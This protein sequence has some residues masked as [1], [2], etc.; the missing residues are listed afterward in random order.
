MKTKSTTQ[1]KNLSRD[2]FELY[3]KDLFLN[4]E[5]QRLFSD[6]KNRKEII[7]INS[8]LSSSFQHQLTLVVEEEIRRKVETLCFLQYAMMNSSGNWTDVGQERIIYSLTRMFQKIP[9][10]QPLS[11]EMISKTRTLLNEESRKYKDLNEDELNKKEEQIHIDLGWKKVGFS[12]YKIINNFL[13]LLNSNK[14]LILGQLELYSSIIFGSTSVSEFSNITVFTFHKELIHTPAIITSIAAMVKDQ[15]I[16]IREDSA[17]TIFYNKWVETFNQLRSPQLAKILKDPAENVSLSIKLQTLAAYNVFT[18][19]QLLKKKSLFIEEILE[20]LLWHEMGHAITLN[21]FMKKREIALDEAL[22]VM[23]E[24]SSSVAKEL[25]ADLAKTVDKTQGALQFIVSCPPQKATRMIL[26]YL[27]DNWFISASDSFFKNHTEIMISNILNFIDINGQLQQKELS[28]QIPIIYQ[29]LLDEYKEI[30]VKFL[31]MLDQEKYILNT[32]L[33]SFDDIFAHY[34]TKFSKFTRHF[35]KRE[36]EAYIFARIINDLQALNNRLFL[37]IQGDLKGLNDKYH[38]RI[39]KG[40]EKTLDTLYRNLKEKKLYAK[41]KI[42]LDIFKDR[43]S[44]NAT[45][46]IQNILDGK[47]N[48][49]LSDFNNDKEI[50]EFLSWLL[51]KIAFTNKTKMTTNQL[52]S[53]WKEYIA[54]VHEDEFSF[55]DDN[56][57]DPKGLFSLLFQ[58]AFIIDSKSLF[59]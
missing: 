54:L 9:Y 49:K 52:I 42:S 3:K 58:V 39:N 26:V 6:L 37:N 27:S 56:L 14:R 24:T 50:K 33:V 18:T 23:G 1:L 7:N 22:S 45:E 32:K 44:N 46:T 28:S 57:L 21:S 12:N 29:S 35:S 5:L 38:H 4:H 19:N 8:P 43:L 31:S 41:Q 13:D 40:K 53:C 34:K 20:G 10:D 16:I 25:L 36:R 47:N 59:Y 55:Y 17:K 15:E 51:Q 48:F 30:L 11:F 2:N